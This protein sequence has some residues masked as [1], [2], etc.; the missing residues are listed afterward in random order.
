MDLSKQL[1]AQSEDIRTQGKQRLAL[2]YLVQADPTQ[3]RSSGSYFC[4]LPDTA[5]L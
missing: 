4:L 3:L 2:I 5:A 1:F